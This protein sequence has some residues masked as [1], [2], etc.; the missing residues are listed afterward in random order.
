MISE[1]CIQC[2][3][4]LGLGYDFLESSNDGNVVV[5]PGTML[6]DDIIENLKK[7]C[8]AGAFKFG[9]N[10]S[11]KRAL[12][13]LREKLINVR[14]C[15]LPTVKDFPFNKDE[16]KISLPISSGRSGYDYSSDDAAERAALSEFK[17]KMYSQIDNL[18]LKVI[19]EYRIKYVRPYYTKDIEQ[20]SVYAKVNLEVNGIIEGIKKI[21]AKDTPKALTLIEVY[22][23]RDMAWELL[24]KG[25]LLSNE[26][27]SDV[28]K[29]FNRD[30]DLYSC[31]WSTDYIEQ[32][33]GK[34]IFGN[35]K[36]KEKY[37]Y[38]NVSAAYEE[39]A[40]DLITSFG[41]A[42]DDLEEHAVE[43]TSWLVEAYNKALREEINKRIKALDAAI[44]NIKD[45]S[46]LENPV[47]LKSY[48]S[49]ERRVSYNSEKQ[50]IRVNGQDL[51]EKECF[52]AGNNE[53]QI[54]FDG[55]SLYKRYIDKKYNMVMNEILFPENRYDES[56]LI[57][58]K[59]ILL[60]WDNK[61]TI[62]TYFIKE[63][64]KYTIAREAHN[65][66]CIVGDKVCYSKWDYD[67]RFASKS[68]YICD[69]NGNNS[70]IIDSTP[71]SEDML[72]FYN[73]RVENNKLKYTIANIL[74]L[75]KSVEKEI[76]LN[77]LI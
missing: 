22:P 75:E 8:P 76:N 16:Y 61:N 42:K 59:N 21:L 26:M 62:S 10:V 70:R 69:L 48:K 35:Y 58:K 36:T 24:N 63:G 53:I 15:L 17:C 3:S 39:L 47:H 34:N 30:A 64:K 23:D 74:H 51:K 66:V 60:L 46:T 33:A 12:L 55:D 72:L 2:G 43:V 45:K 77:N 5:K 37:C 18:I 65:I 57:G 38:K 14:G 7:I 28:K 44:A 19:T 6:N 9:E 4:C 49:M 67:N 68:L 1:K 56:L 41:W 71:Y 13:D 31:M 40:K 27:I 54:F 20:G 11:K 25:E 73:A 50:C 32:P 29:E 52:V